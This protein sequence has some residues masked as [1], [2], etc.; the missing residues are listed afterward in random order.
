MDE[1]LTSPGSPII[2]LVGGLTLLAVALLAAPVVSVAQSAAP[3]SAAGVSQ[4]NFP[5]GPYVAI[6]CGFSHRNN[7]DPI[8]Y[9]GQPGRSHNHTYVGNRTVNASTT[10]ASLLRGPTTCDLEED[11]STYWVPT[12][13]V[14]SE[15]IAPL[16]GVV[17]YTKQVFGPVAA[18]PAGL[19]MVAGNPTARRAQSK[20]I[21][22]WGC[23]GVGG[24][25]RFAV[26]R[27]C[28]VDDALDLEVV[29]PNCWNGRSTDSSNH[30]RHMAYS[31]G[32]D[33]PA[34]HPVRL[35]TITLVLLYPP[36]AGRAQTSAGKFATHADFINGWDQDA[37]ARLTSGLNARS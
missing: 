22:S 31:K 36:L 6:V 21:V 26:I 3:D 28:G 15:P 13:Y 32:G 8:R 23:G 25:P 10:S 34:T 29:F 5:G 24:V 30:K 16:A 1:G 18:A 2:R 17:Y 4:R 14:G 33:C 9:P 27:A 20:S 37:L 7:D 12:V 35:P 19:K 11:S